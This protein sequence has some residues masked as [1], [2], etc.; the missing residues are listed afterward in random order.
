MPIKNITRSIQE[1][2]IMNAYQFV[3]ENDIIETCRCKERSL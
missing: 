3:Y 2:N 1:T